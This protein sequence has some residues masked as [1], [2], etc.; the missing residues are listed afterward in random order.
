MVRVRKNAKN[1]MKKSSIEEG[2]AGQAKATGHAVI[3]K[4]TRLMLT[5]VLK[6][7]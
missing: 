5:A 1:T 4:A 2:L 3:T 6:E 7:L